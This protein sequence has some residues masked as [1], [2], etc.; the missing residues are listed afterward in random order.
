MKKITAILIIMCLML[1]IAVSAADEI[2]YT[3]ASQEFKTSRQWE[4]GE[5]GY[6]GVDAAFTNAVSGDY[7]DWRLTKEKAGPYRVYYWVTL[8]EDGA[9]EA[10]LT[11]G[12]ETQSF[13]RNLS[14][15]DGKAGWWE[16]GVMDYGH[17]GAS[18][19]LVAQSG[20]IFASAIKLIPLDERYNSV[21]EI[22]RTNPGSIVIK[23]GSNKTY[24]NGASGE[25]ADVVP[26]IYGKTTLVPIRYISDAFGAQVFWDDEKQEVKIISEGKTIV[27]VPGSSDYTVDGEK[28]TLSDAPAIE[29]GRTLVP[30]RAVSEGLGK[31]VFWDDTGVIIIGG[32]I[33]YSKEN[34]RALLDNLSSILSE[35][36][37]FNAPPAKDDQEKAEKAVICKVRGD[38]G[39][40]V[41]FTFD[42]G[43]Y[44]AAK[45]YNELLKQYSMKGTAM[46]ITDNV[47]DRAEDWRNLFKDGYIDIGNHSMSHSLRYKTDNPDASLLENDITRSYGLLEQLFPQNKILT[48]AAPWGQTSPQATAEMQKK[49]AANFGVN[50]SAFA[51]L[52]PDDMQWYNI[53]RKAAQT[54]STPLEDMNKWIDD[55]ISGGKWLVELWHGIGYEGEGED[56]DG[57][58]ADSYNLPEETYRAHMEYAFSK[59]DEFWCASANEA[60][61]YIKE[62]QNAALSVISET[63]EKLTLSLTDNLDNAIYNEALTLKIRVDTSKSE[64]SCSVGGVQKT[65]QVNSDQNGRY[66]LIDAVPDSGDIVIYY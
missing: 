33:E 17:A 2:I 41:T 42:D 25:I 53:P 59:A 14:F 15:S 29:N 52:D 39:A 46:L 16:F 7:A 65:A 35:E 1:P 22:T 38:L 28:R 45:F 8:S 9:L 48:F 13:T 11:F 34:D 10:S 5:Y 21:T 26:K 61:K 50:T 27:F 51:S 23:V 63:D 18:L 64:L 20:K 55:A 66:L 58:T 49:H 62:R 6:N 12:S 57:N 32:A 24:Q 43:D 19:R 47:K 30:I 36:N 31:K 40:I 4:K 60:V 44:Q 54:I 56:D 3:T 37:T